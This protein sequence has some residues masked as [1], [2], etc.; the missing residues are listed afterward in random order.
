MQ[1]FRRSTHNAGSYKF[2]YM[3]D[4]HL[5]V[6]QQYSTFDFPPTAPYLILAGDIGRL[7]DYD[8]LLLF[9]TKQT[10]RFDAVF[11]VLGN[12]EFYGTSRS[13]GLELVSQSSNQNFIC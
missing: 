11:Y 13:K 7:I 6:G 2:Q 3:S 1:I 10:S 8:K 5:E 9:L 12:H 4:L